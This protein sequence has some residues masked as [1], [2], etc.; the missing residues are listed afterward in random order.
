[1]TK[2]DNV[3]VGQ[4]F[5]HSSTIKVKKL[6]QKAHRVKMSSRVEWF[7]NYWLSC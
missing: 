3:S 6:V 2:C 7:L 5:S 4:D 1:M